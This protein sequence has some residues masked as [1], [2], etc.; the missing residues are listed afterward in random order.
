MGLDPGMVRSPFLLGAHVVSDA[1]IA[2]AMPPTKER[3]VESRDRIT[4]RSPR[5]PAH[6]GGGKD[7]MTYTTDLSR[8]AATT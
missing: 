3:P 4:P 1:G 5:A 7:N 6:T 8:E 2:R